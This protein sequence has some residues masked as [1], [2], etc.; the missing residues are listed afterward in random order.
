M[1]APISDGLSLH[2]MDDNDHTA[3]EAGIESSGSQRSTSPLASSPA[4]PTELK[5]TSTSVPVRPQSIVQTAVGLPPKRAVQPT[6][7]KTQQPQLTESTLLA[8]HSTSLNT[9]KETSTSPKTRFRPRERP[10]KGTHETPATCTATQN[11]IEHSQSPKSPSTTLTDETLDQ[12]LSLNPAYEEPALRSTSLQG[13]PLLSASPP[14]RSLLPFRNS[15]LE[16]KQ[17]NNQRRPMFTPAVL[18]SSSSITGFDPSRPDGGIESVRPRM[19]SSSSASSLASTNSISS[20]WS[21]LRGGG[22]PDPQR[23]K[24]QWGPTRTHWKPNSSRFSC[25]HCRRVFNY[26]TPARRKHHCRACGELFCG[27]CVKNYIYLDKDANFAI[28]GGAE[29]PGTV[30]KKYLCKVC[31]D[32]AHH[33]EQF[34]KDHTKTD[35]DL[36]RS[37]DY[38]SSRGSGRRGS[39][40]VGA[41]P[42]DWDWSS[43]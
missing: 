14:S 9:V 34:L 37:D 8:S 10:A 41:V 27:D 13:S 39:A 16:L 11:S 6:A 3:A 4:V 36:G 21:Y 15:N 42:A 17:I 22:T 32:C 18:R 5:T 24:E 38:N 43:F 26:M 35:H 33:Y 1:T 30:E 40:F 25:L 12:R 31:V 19:V 20:Y 23:V 2:R 7:A 29:E 28:F